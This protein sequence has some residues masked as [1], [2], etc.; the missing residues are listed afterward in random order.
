M[1]IENHEKWYQEYLKLTELK[2]DAIKKW[3]ENRQVGYFLI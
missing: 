2:K 1:E 3:K